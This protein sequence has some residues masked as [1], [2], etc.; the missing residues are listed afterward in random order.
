MNSLPLVLSGVIY[1]GRNEQVRSG[2]GRYMAVKAVAK[3]IGMSPK[4][5]RRILSTVRGKKVE[6][7]LEILRFLPSPAAKAVAKVV[8][9]AAN[10]A[11]NNNMMSPE[12]LRIVEIRADV[13]PTLKRFRA[14]SRGRASRIIKRSSH[15]TVIVDEEGGNS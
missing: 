12:E 3:N 9:S 7:A 6:A 2:E 10:N 4:K 14:R 11:E 5:M 1:L 8:K 13:G 15:I